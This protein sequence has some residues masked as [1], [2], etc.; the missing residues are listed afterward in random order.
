MKYYCIGIKGSG[1]AAL[2]CILYDLGNEVLGYDDNQ[3]QKYTQIGLDKRKIIIN[4]N[5]E[6]S[7]E[8]IVTYSKAISSEHP[9]LIRVKKMGLKIIEYSVLMGEISKQFWTIGISGT[10]GKTTTTTMI[11]HIINKAYGCNYFIGDG[12]GYAKSDNK[13][14]VMES[15]EFNKHFINYYPKLSI[16]TNIE[17]EHMECYE[18]LEDIIH[19]FN[20]FINNNKSTVIACGDN[21]NVLKL[22][23][24]NKIIYYGFNSNN[25]YLI[26]D[27]ML[28]EFGSSFNLYYQD[29]LVGKYQIPLYG[30]HM[31]LDTVAAIIVGKLLNI[32]DEVIQK[33][34][35]TFKNAK[36]RLEI[37]E[38][39]NSI[40]VDDYAHHP[41]EIAVT[42]NSIRQKYPSKKIIAIFKPNTYSRTKDFYKEFAESLNLADTCYLTEIDCNREKPDE[43]P[44]ITSKLILDRLNNGH[45]LKNMKE[46]LKYNDNV[47]LFMSCAS[48]ENIKSELIDLL[49][50]Y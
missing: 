2:A 6:L 36:R 39:N 23:S 48:I 16:V 46:L 25:D 42:I 26:K 30:K 14:F 22:K 29:S 9:E 34:L 40:I 41:T 31:V 20:I 37:T 3:D 27:I 35:S 18:N 12:Q 17:L 43:Y 47:Y 50:K 21:E 10:H 7:K 13:Y 44:E 49:S 5:I 24:N 11:S 15:D 28:N 4:G 19:N 33:E 1:M 8:T 32:N 38:V 45:M